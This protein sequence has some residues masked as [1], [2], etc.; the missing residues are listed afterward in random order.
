MDKFRELA[1]EFRTVFTGRSNLIDAILPPIAFVMVNAAVGLS[2][3]IWSSLA[4]ALCITAFRLLRRQPLRYAF[5]G[6]GGVALAGLIAWLLGRAEGY[7]VP[8]LVT[9]VLT[10]VACVASVLLGRPLVAW[11]SFL[12]RRWPLAWY[13]HPQVRPAYSQVTWFWAL[14]FTLRLLF[15]FSFFQRASAGLL[16]V[17]NLLTGWPVTIVLLVVSYL[18]GTWQLR[19]LGGPSVQEFKAGAPPPWTGQRRGF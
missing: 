9:G 18:Y 10:V 2:H 4:V 7:F 12:T 5:G 13:W 14:F 16:A 17:I 8:G 11:T 19:R 1:E 3:A 15:Q 6:L